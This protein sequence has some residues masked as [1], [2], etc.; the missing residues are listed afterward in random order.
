MLWL[1]DHVCLQSVRN[2]EM[3]LDFYSAFPCQNILRP[4]K[5]QN[6]FLPYS[7]Y[8][9]GI[10]VAGWWWNRI[11]KKPHWQRHLG[12]QEEVLA[13]WLVFRAAV[14]VPRALCCAGTSGQHVPPR[15]YCQTISFQTLSTYW[16]ST[17]S[18][19]TCPTCF[20]Q[21]KA[22]QFGALH[23]MISSEKLRAIEMWWLGL[24]QHFFSLQKIGFV[25][26]DGFWGSS[27]YEEV[28]FLK[29]VV[30]R[31]HTTYADT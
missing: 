22:F 3:S 19:E 10:F 20:G 14:D 9:R 17:C 30:G 28:I 16:R 15:C 31:C 11:A 26:I 5:V 7:H 6:T 13:S 4:L 21:G 27:S 8:W 18:G 29:T 23:M 24:N 1:P 2:V 12:K 25:N